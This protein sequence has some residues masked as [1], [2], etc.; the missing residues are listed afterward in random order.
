MPRGTLRDALFYFPSSTMS[1]D[2]PISPNHYARFKI[3][4][5]EFI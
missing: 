4:P 2:N 5:I 3:Q 1:K